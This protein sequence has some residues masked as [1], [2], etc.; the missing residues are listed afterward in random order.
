MDKGFEKVRYAYAKGCSLSHTCGDSAGMSTLSYLHNA[1]SCLFIYYLKGEGNIKIE[2][3]IYDI[4]EGDIAM[5]SPSELYRCEIYAETYHERIVLRVDYSIFDNFSID[6]RELVAPFFKREK[7]CANLVSR[8]NV[9]GK[10]LGKLFCDLL[11]LVSAETPSKNL[12][13]VC[14]TMELLDILK[15]QIKT[16]Q[17]TQKPKREN[18]LI[19]NVILYI[20]DHFCDNI[21]VSDIASVFSVNESYLSHLFKEFVGVSPWNYII[22]K[23]INHFNSLILKSYTIEEAFAASGFQNYSNFFRLYKKYMNITPSEFR[24]GNKR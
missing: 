10:G 1:P 17:K 24:R 21:S 18:P 3:K 5:I 9:D 6:A 8:E 15:D 13:A 19:N 22:S 7:G 14:K 2:G 12:L 4:H 11:E 20:N 23:R 16:A